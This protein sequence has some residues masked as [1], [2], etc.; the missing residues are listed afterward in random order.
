M[1]YPLS[2]KR[3]WVAG[4]NGMVGSALVRALAARGD[5]SIIKAGRD[6]VDLKDQAAV[7]HWMK[8]ECPDAIVLAAA[9]VGGILDNATYPADYLYDN[10][11]IEANIIEA[12][13]RE[14]VGKLLFLGSTCI[15]PKLAEQPINRRDNRVGERQH[16]EPVQVTQQPAQAQRRQPRQVPL[17]PAPDEIPRQVSRRQ[18]R[19]LL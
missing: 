5:V 14:D 9:K 6:I 8:Q 1:I 11:L 16:A 17:L 3:L 13:H 19:N 15:Y 4:H 12:A 7:R 18:R 10:L 2:G